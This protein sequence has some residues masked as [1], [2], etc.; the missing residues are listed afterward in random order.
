MAFTERWVL[1]GGEGGGVFQL[2]G[3]TLGAK[4]VLRERSESGAR[5]LRRQGKDLHRLADAG[6]F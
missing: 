4:L 2:S 1:V 3:I 5:N 6:L